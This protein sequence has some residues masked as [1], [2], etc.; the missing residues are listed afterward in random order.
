MQN[1]GFVFAIM[2][3]ARRE[4]RTSTDIT[5]FLQRHLQLFNTHPYLS[6]AVLGSVVSIEETE[7]PDQ[8]GSLII[9]LKKTLTGPYAAIGD[10]FFWGTLRPFAAVVAVAL[11]LMDIPWAPIVFIVLYDSFHLRIRWKGFLESYRLG[12]QGFQYV[13]AL[14]LHALNPKIRWL[15][16]TGLALF[17]ACWLQAARP[18]D[19]SG[20]DGIMIASAVLLLVVVCNWAIRKRIS[21]LILLYLLAMVFFLISM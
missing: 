19:M 20:W 6:A 3:L 16:V 21:P 17:L 15:S 2:P 4:G 9:Q 5:S 8:N 18:A 14:N 7:A 13:Q 1:L 12:H 10:T 11:G